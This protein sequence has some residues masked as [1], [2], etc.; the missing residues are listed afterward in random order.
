MGKMS[1]CSFKSPC[2][3]LVGVVRGNGILLAGPRSLV[4]AVR[5]SLRKRCGTR[6]QMVGARPTDA[7]GIVMLNR[8]V[9]WTEEGTRISLEFRHV[10]E[11]IEELGLEGARC[12]DTPHGSGAFDHWPC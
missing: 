2:G 5:K 12:A 9:Q 4:D 11:I 6:E 8:R 3:K 10:R 1:K 7:S